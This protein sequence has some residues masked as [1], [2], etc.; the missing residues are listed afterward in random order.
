M[1]FFYLPYGHCILIIRPYAPSLMIILYSLCITLIATTDLFGGCCVYSKVIA[2]P[3][4]NPT[5]GAKRRS[6][7]ASYNEVKGVVVEWPL[8]LRGR[9]AGESSGSLAMA[10][11]FS[12]NAYHTPHYEVVGQPYLSDIHPNAATRAPGV[13]QSILAHE[14]VIEHVAK[15][16][17]LPMEVVQVG[18]SGPVWRTLKAR[19]VNIDV[20]FIILQSVVY[21]HV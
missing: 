21:R 4:R 6:D 8:C 7:R 20:C 15:T 13:V 1:T 2:M 9:Y 10:V 17:G 3:K 16:V 19:P 18:P 12:D 5:S 14:V 11:A